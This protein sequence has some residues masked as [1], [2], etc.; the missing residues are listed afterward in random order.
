[1]IRRNSQLLERKPIELSSTFSS[2]FASLFV[3]HWTDHFDNQ[4]IQLPAFTGT[5]F[6]FPSFEHVREYLRLK[7]NECHNRHLNAVTFHALLSKHSD[8][9]EVVSLLKSKYA[10]KSSKNELLFSDFQI[11]YNNEP[12][13]FRKG[14][15]VALVP[16]NN[17]DSSE[18]IRTFHLKLNDEFFKQT[19][20]L[21]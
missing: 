13:V 4:L 12:E 6:V 15:F 17:S 18:S 21:V 5:C 14:S 19:N 2:Y 3:R 7:Q 8:P 16:P 9:S 10:G 11:N 20:L 1:M